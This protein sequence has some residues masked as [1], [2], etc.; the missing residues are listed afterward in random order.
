MNRKLIHWTTLTGKN[1]HCNNN[2]SPDMTP[3]RTMAVFSVVIH[4]LSQ[5]PFFKMSESRERY[6]AVEISVYE[7]S[8]QC[9]KKIGCDGYRLMVKS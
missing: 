1:N 6:I 3:R 4:T 9:E 2:Q 7:F 8:M 5:Q